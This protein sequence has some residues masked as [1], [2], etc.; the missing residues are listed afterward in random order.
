MP[1]AFL[2]L[3]NLRLHNSLRRVEREMGAARAPEDTLRRVEG[4]CRDLSVLFLAVARANGFAGRFV[5]GYFSPAGVQGPYEL[6][7]LG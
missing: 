5:S 1:R 6:A 2:P 4:S 3:L 7:R